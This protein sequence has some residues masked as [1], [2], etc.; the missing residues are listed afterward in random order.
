[1]DD[2]T[3]KFFSGNAPALRGTRGRRGLG[4]MVFVAGNWIPNTPFLLC[5]TGAGGQNEKRVGQFET[6][7]FFDPRFTDATRMRR[8]TDARDALCFLVSAHHSTPSIID[9]VPC[10]ADRTLHAY[11][12]FFRES[13]T[14]FTSTGASPAAA[15]R[16]R[17]TSGDIICYAS[18]DADHHAHCILPRRASPRGVEA[19]SQGQGCT[20]RRTNSTGR[21]YV[22]VGTGR[23]STRCRNTLWW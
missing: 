1:M 13:T 6:R 14:F 8:P 16:T 7:D 2:M 20:D 9:G 11:H 22:V 18:P 12:G 21:C 19:D 15:R 5:E 17:V 10:N 3:R 23:H 4:P